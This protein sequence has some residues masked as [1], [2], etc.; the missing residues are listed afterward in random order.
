MSKKF[1]PVLLIL[2]CGGLFL[3]YAVMGRGDKGKD[4]PKTRYEK[5]LRNICVPFHTSKTIKPR[6]LKGI[7]IQ[8]GI[9][10]KEWINKK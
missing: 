6:T 5:I 10:Q 2:V 7:I 1:L 8:S 9:S 4:D 3:T